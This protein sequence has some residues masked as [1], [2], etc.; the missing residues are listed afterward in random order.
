MKVFIVPDIHLKPWMIEKAEELID[1]T[2]CEK[3]MF[4]GDIADDWG[5]QENPALYKE[6]Y[7]KV[8]SFM[9]SHQNTLFCYGNHD[10]AY[11]WGTTQ[12]GYSHNPEVREVVINGLQAI[13]TTL[14][15]GACA[16]IHKI[17]DTLFSHGGLTESFV[18]DVWPSN[19]PVYTM[20]NDINQWGKPLLWRDN[21]PIWGTTPEYFQWEQTIST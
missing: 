1:D 21:S 10:I 12:T 18:I 16:F 7:D 6:T 3:I 20:I 15:D 11:V 13:K 17:G 14:P 8:V 19:T 2:L 5:Q 9:K 4:L